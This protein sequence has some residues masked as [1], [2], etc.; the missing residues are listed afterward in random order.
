MQ[1]RA[2]SVAIGEELPSEE[3]GWQEVERVFNRMGSAGKLRW[4]AGGRAELPRGRLAPPREQK[5]RALA[6][7]AQLLSS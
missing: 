7:R 2:C 4:G 3:F 1:A 5:L 6:P